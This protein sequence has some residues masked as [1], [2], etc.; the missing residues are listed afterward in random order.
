MKKVK[1]ITTSIRISPDDRKNME[2]SNIRVQEVIDCFVDII[3][4]VGAKEAWRLIYEAKIRSELK[5]YMD[6]NP[7]P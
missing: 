5:S 1:S 4:A 2:E 3:D 6:S 7:G